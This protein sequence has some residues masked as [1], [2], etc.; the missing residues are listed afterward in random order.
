MAD[1]RAPPRFAFSRR[2]PS[3][4]LALAETRREQGA[5]VRV[6]AV[7]GQPRDRVYCAQLLA[8]TAGQ[9]FV[10]LDLGLGSADTGEE[11]RVLERALALARAV[12]ATLFI[13]G[14][15]TLFERRDGPPGQRAELLGGY[16]K[17]ALGGFGGT[18]VLGMPEQVE[19][20]YERLPALDIEVTFRAPSGAVIA[21]NPLLLPSQLIKEPLLP[22]HNFMIRI[23][24]EAV[25][26]G[27][28]SAPQLVAGPINELDFDPAQGIQA[29]V[30]LPPDERA[31]WP[32]VTLRRAVSQSRL[33]FDWKQAQADG[34]PLL[35]TVELR[36]LDWQTSRVVNTW[37]LRGCWAKRWTGPTFDAQ[38]AAVAEE[39]LEL[40]YQHVQWR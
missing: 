19:A 15:E 30:D 2:D 5:G 29:F 38:R 17:R 1:G 9:V 39:A 3:P 4:I 24:G 11:K 31:A 6:L 23:D 27:A 8:N 35:R 28:V 13:D 7:G 37:V 12:P 16:L 20:D 14:A 25:G 40:Y 36:Q 33:L 26:L 32:T 22:A 21:G 18:V 10:Q 34:K